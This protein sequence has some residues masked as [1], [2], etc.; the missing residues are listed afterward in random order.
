MAA[1]LCTQLAVAA[2][3]VGEP[4][5]ASLQKAVQLFQAK[6]Y[7]D[8]IPLLQMVQGDPELGGEV[9]LLLGICLYRTQELQKAEPLLRKASES[10]DTETREAAQLFLGLLFDE[11]GATDQAQ[12]Q[13]GKAAGS[14][15]FGGS[16]QKLLEQRRTHR[17]LISL[18][19]APEF[20]G[21]VRLTDT[22]TWK[23]APT[24]ASDGDI[25][26]LASLGIRP[27]RFGLSVG[28]VLSYR[29]QLRLRDYSLLLDSTWLGYSYA[30]TRNRFRIHTAFDIAMLGGNQLFMDFDGR[31]SDRLRLWSQLGIAA[32]YGF[33]HRSYASSDY[34]SLSGQTHQGQL[35]LSWGT[36]PEPLCVQIGYVLLRDQLEAPLLP[37]TSTDD[38]RA[39]AHGPQLRMRA[40]L[41]QRVEWSLSAQY[42]RRLFDYLPGPE[43]PAEM[44]ISRLDDFVS[45]DTS[46]AVRFGGYFET[47]VGGSMVVN[48]SNKDAFSYLK[49]TAYL[50]IAAYFGLL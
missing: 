44:G 9:V 3:P 20:D 48:R 50:G 31:V 25:L 42:L 16:A 35:E 45:A 38:Y 12:D 43:I 10:P 24:D 23:D 41:H 26:L 40:R 19:V 28:N 39:W 21:N 6:R 14:L 47:F 36:M 4:P 5:Q 18:M 33:R 32:S 11:L 30:S 13:L 2:S 27:F 37:L 1:L 34:Q 49:P 15:S 29:Q 17:L 8:A 7:A 22:T 46:L